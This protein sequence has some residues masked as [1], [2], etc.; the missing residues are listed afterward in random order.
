MNIALGHIG[1]PI[2]LE[3]VRHSSYSSRSMSPD[4]AS[5]TSCPDLKILP[6][7]VGAFDQMNSKTLQTASGSEEANRVIRWGRRSSPSSVTRIASTR[8]SPSFSMNKCAVS[9][10]YASR[11][12]WIKPNRTGSSVWENCRGQVKPDSSEAM[13]QQNRLAVKLGEYGTTVAVVLGRRTAFSNFFSRYWASLVNNRRNAWCAY[14]AS[15]LY[16]NTSLLC[17]HTCPTA[18]LFSVRPAREHDQIPQ[19]L[20]ALQGLKFIQLSL[21]T[22]IVSTSVEWVVPP[23]VR[24]HVRGSNYVSGTFDQRRLCDMNDGFWGSQCKATVDF[25]WWC[26]PLLFGYKSF[27]RIGGDLLSTRMMSNPHSIKFAVGWR[28]G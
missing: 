14:C 6:Q 5:R 15:V 20:H 3:G 26:R 17:M 4:P 9:R 25:K 19:G 8:K 7:L 12:R 22:S 28:K 2:I 23:G 16:F 1:S 24:Q 21:A 11:T 13:S 10:R 18:S 27:C